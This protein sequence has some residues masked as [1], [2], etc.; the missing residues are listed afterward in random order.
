MPRISLNKGVSLDYMECGDPNGSPMLFIHGYNDSMRVW[1]LLRP[2]LPTDKRQIYVSLRGYGDSDKPESG[3][4]MSD[5]MDDIVEFIEQRELSNIIL[6]GHSM[7]GFISHQL[8]LEYPQYVQKLVLIGTAPT[9]AS[10]ETIGGTDGDEI[11][12]L[13]DPVDPDY[14]RFAQTEQIMSPVDSDFIEGFLYET[15]KAPARVWQLAMKGMITED[16]SD[17]LKNI[18]VPTLILFG[19]GDIFFNRDEQQQFLDAIPDSKL[20]VY[21]GV[22]HGIHWEIPEQCGKDISDFVG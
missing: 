7:G 2:Y 1:D 17:Q 13:T 15:A 19:D 14:I 20:I 5:F 4:E 11:D 16:H 18:Q 12:R 22:G 8:A 6:L 21:P 9:G 3:Y 10:S